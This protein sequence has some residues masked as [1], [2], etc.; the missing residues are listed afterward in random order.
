MISPQ[1]GEWNGQ[2]PL[3]GNDETRMTKDVRDVRDV[4]DVKSALR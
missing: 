2:G 1:E 3:W 4:R